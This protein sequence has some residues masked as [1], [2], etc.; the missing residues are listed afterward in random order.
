M[1]GCED[2]LLPSKPLTDYFASPLLCRSQWEQHC[3][4]AGDLETVSG[5]SLKH[6]HV[7]YFQ[8]L[9]LRF[10]LESNHYVYLFERWSISR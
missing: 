10:L 3:L 2:S 7:T 9:Q 8:F 4:L 5:E 1:R 6:S